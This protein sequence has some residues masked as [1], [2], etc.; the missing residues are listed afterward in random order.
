[1]SLPLP[2]RMR[3]Y[4]STH[5][6]PRFGSSRARPVVSGAAGALAGA[7]VWATWTWAPDMAA[8][9]SVAVVVALAAVMIA[10]VT[11][12]P[13]RTTGSTEDRRPAASEDA[14]QGMARVAPAST[15]ETRNLDETRVTVEADDNPVVM[16]PAW[17]RALRSRV[18]ILEAALTDQDASLARA[19]AQLDAS[20]N[21]REGDIARVRLT[22]QALRERVGVNPESQILLDR[23]EAAVSRLS[24]APGLQRP[25]LPAVSGE[26]PRLAPVSPGAAPDTANAL[27]P[28]AVVPQPSAIAH[29]SAAT[30]PAAE[31]PPETP[32]TST[33][34]ETGAV[35]PAPATRVLPVPA[36]PVQSVPRAGRWRRRGAV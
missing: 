5:P 7:L 1:M 35:P 26:E 31:P 28:V 25:T 17:L 33:E 18:H 6:S 15:V 8:A 2:P 22:L 4:Q 30:T 23:V 14:E 21:R 10:V 12:S 24:P 19:Q 36:P 16:E 9:T 34:E 29:T 27:P 20:H 11:G 3:S 32:D 13:T